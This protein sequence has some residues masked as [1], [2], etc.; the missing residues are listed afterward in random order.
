MSM[1]GKIATTD[2]LICAAHQKKFFD[3]VARI[4]A[5]AFC[6]PF[7]AITIRRDDRCHLIG[8]YGLAVRQLPAGLDLGAFADA[9]LLFED[10]QRESEP[11][12]APLQSGDKPLR[13]FASVPIF[14]ERFQRIGL[15]VVADLHPRSPEK[16]L[17]S[18]L[19]GIAEITGNT[20]RNMDECVISQNNRHCIRCNQNL[21]NGAIADGVGASGF[22]ESAALSDPGRRSVAE[23]MLLDTLIR[24]KSVIS[25]NA[26]SYLSLRAWR[27]SLKKHQVAALREIKTAPTPAFVDTVSQEIANGLDRLVGERP[28]RIVTHVPCG[29]SR[30]DDCL[31]SL[32][33]KRLAAHLN[34][35]FVSAFKPNFS[36]GTSHP[37]ANLIRPAMEIDTPIVDPVLLIDD[38][39]SSGRHMEEAVGLLRQSAEVVLPVAWI[40]GEVNAN[41]S[42]AKS[43]AAPEL[44]TV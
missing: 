29:H 13:F 40:G 25:R 19:Q 37:K 44:D 38:V 3:D 11:R 12:L 6:A 5:A 39:A 32:L 7:G 1:E 22:H 9:P 21:D 16:Q 18:T 34:L 20:L 30:K 36:A 17:I 35:P 4:A 14:N 23:T 8:R 28:A 26:V 43:P 27:K 24:R 10:L 41:R 31:S 42:A 2:R 15:V 33:A